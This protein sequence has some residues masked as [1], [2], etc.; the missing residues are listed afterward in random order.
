VKRFAGVYQLEE[1]RLTIE[2]IGAA[3]RLRLKTQGRTRELVPESGTDFFEPDAD[4]TYHFVVQDDTVTGV[5]V[6]VP[7]KIVFRKVE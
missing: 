4:R 5:E 1:D 6:A 3:G 7:E 2:A